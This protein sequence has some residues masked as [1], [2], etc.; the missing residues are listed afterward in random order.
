MSGEGERFRELVGQLVVVDTDSHHLYIGKL[1][2]VDDTALEL[3][4]AD[5]HDSQTTT[6]PRDVYIINTSK[7]GIKE[8]RRRVLVRM[9]R[10]LSI[11][12]LEDVTQY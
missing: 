1:E 8:N 3:T 4:D 9:E 5:V 12:A 10:V 6:T 11:S 7:F 2:S